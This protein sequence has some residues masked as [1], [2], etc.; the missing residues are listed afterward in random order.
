MSSARVE[1]T[2]TSCPM[3]SSL[4]AVHVHQADDEEGK[5]QHDTNET[6]YKDE[7]SLSGLCCII[8]F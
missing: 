1:P 4:P 6:E 3:Q 5:Y 2:T 8:G 7:D